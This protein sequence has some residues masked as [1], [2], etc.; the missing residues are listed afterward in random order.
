[1]AEGGADLIE[2]VYRFNREF[3]RA[4]RAKVLLEYQ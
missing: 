1:M 3:F 2:T 4:V